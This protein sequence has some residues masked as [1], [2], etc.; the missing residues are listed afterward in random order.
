MVRKHL[1]HTTLRTFGRKVRRV[2]LFDQGR[3]LPKL[4]V[5]PQFAHF[6]I[7]YFLSKQSCLEGCC[8]IQQNY[9][10]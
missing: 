3:F 6:A 5:L 2:L 4:V 10:Y 7:M 1:A 8:Q 9:Q